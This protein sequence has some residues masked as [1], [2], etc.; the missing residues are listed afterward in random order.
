MRGRTEFDRRR[1]LAGVLSGVT[2]AGLGQPVT[3]AETGAANWLDRQFSV[4]PSGPTPAQPPPLQSRTLIPPQF[5]QFREHDPFVAGLRPHRDG[6]MRLG[7]SRPVETSDG[8]R[9][10]IH[11]Y[12]HGGAGMTLSFGSAEQV[13]DLIHQVLN[14]QA[15]P[16]IPPIAILGAGVIGLT[17]ALAIK[18]RWPDVTIT[19]YAATCD[20]A[21]TTSFKAGGMFA[22]ISTIPEYHG[23]AR[24]AELQRTIDRSQT[25]IAQLARNGQGARLGLLRRPTYSFLSRGGNVRLTMGNATRPALAYETWLIDPTV[26]LPA[27]RGDLEA[28][29]VAFITRRLDTLADVYALPQP[30]IVNCT[31]LGARDLFTDTALEGRRGHLVV[32]K[33]DAKLDYLLNSWC[34]SGTRYLFAR[35]SDIVIGGTQR[36]D[37]TAPEFDPS[38]PSDQR[39]CDRILRSARSLFEKGPIRCS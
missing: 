9:Q 6:G 7:L 4:P 5:D 25:R 11:N 37:E 13:V 18:T 28:R 32:L 38:D 8:T 3:A 14:K 1:L 30:I 2:A 20:P 21:K 27:L 15:A 24:R 39:A 29:G 12:G 31:G 23:N 19:I 35:S 17:T 33:N 34:G 10:V 26:L 36:H 16:S 22:P